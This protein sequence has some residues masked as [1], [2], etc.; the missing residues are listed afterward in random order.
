MAE[1]SVW[2]SWWA[3]VQYPK[4]NETEIVPVET[5]LFSVGPLPQRQRT[6]FRPKT[7]TDFKKGQ[8]YI[9]NSS[10]KTS[11][12]KPHPYYAQIGNIAGKWHHAV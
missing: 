2:Q 1:T 5:I 10:H 3:N 4:Y 6:P 12:N 11:D 9:V 8:L 7:V